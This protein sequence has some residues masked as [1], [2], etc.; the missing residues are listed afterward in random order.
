MKN[1]TYLEFDDKASTYLNQSII[2]PTTTDN[3]DSFANDL[4]FDLE[5]NE[6]SIFVDFKQKN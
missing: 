2:R 1:S 3:N 4:D 6:S 5:S